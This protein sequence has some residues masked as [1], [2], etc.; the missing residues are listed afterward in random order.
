MR[1]LVLILALVLTAD[2]AWAESLLHDGI[3][4]TYTVDDAGQKAPA[5]LVLH[6]GGGSGERIKRYTRFTLGRQG[7]TVIYPDAHDKF[8]NDGRV[9]QDGLPLRDTDDVG[10][11]R[12]L[13]S[14]LASEGR[15]DPDR[16][17]A[18]GASNG[19][20]MTQRLIC[21]AP[22]LLAGA[23]ISIMT[24][25]IGL[26]CPAGPPTPMMFIWGT[27]DPLVPYQGGTIQTRRKNRGSVRSAE[28]TLRF[29]ADRN[30]CQAVRSV[31]LPD[32]ND[33]DT[34][35]RKL[36]YSGC[37]APLQAIVMEGGGHVWPGR[38]VPRLLKRMLGNAVFDING[39]EVV[40]EFVASLAQ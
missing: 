8:W 13:L 15:I 33:D 18:V 27:A 31:N 30:R 16:V 25:P 40:E 39:T 19:G 22:G 32:R 1:S 5:L 29:Y 17:F 10:F 2:S 34:Q 11:I 35:V 38:R 12:A 23:V 14:R 21:Q 4:R 36:I 3:E 24:F 7:W 9:G 20:A 26:D 6:G 37:A 28:Q